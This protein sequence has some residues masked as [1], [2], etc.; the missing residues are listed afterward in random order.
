MDKII[1]EFGEVLHKAKDLLRKNEHR[2]HELTHRE[3]EL[4]V[5]EEKLKDAESALAAREYEVQKVENVVALAKSAEDMR[6]ETSKRIE[7]VKADEH[8]LR[9]AQLVHAQKVVDDRKHIQEEA[10]NNQKNHKHIEDEVAKRVNAV[11]VNMG[12]RKA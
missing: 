1:A 10:E 6:A 3:N 11:L 4:S 8:I 12:L 2:A 5:R 7:A 9:Q